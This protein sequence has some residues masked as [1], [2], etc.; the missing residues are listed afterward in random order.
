MSKALLFCVMV[1]W[2]V[3]FMF[4]A[5]PAARSISVAGEWRLRLDPNDAGLRED[6]FKKADAFPDII[7]LPSSTDEQHF[8][9]RN[10]ARDPGHLT[11]AYWFIGAVWYEREVT[12]PEA[13]KSKRITLF[14][15]RCHWETQAWF[16]GYPLGLQNSLS[17]PQAYEVSQPGLAIVT[18][19]KHR[20]TLR[21]DNRR[22][23]DVG[24]SSAVTE[25]GP[26][27]WNGIAGGMELRATDAVWIDKVFTYPDLARNLV[28]IKLR[29]RNS[30]GETQAAKL[31][32]AVGGGKSVTDINIGCHPVEVIEQDLRVAGPTE[33]WSE[34]SPTIQALDVSIAS[35]SAA[36]FFDEAH[37]TFGMR[38]LATA[39]KQML[40]NGRVIHLR[41]TVD[42]GSFPLKG[43]PPT[44]VA[45]WRARFHTYKDY[46]FNHVRF[47]S[48]C[49]PE[50]AFT[51]ADELGLI[52]QVE[53]PMWIPDGRVSANVLRTG[54]IRQ[55]AE[56]IVDTY[57]NHPSFGLMTMGNELGSA[58]DVF[59]RNLVQSLQA[60]DPRHLYTSTSAPDNMLRPDDYFVSAG[61]RWQNLRGDPRLEANPPDTDFDYRQ[62]VD[63]LDRPVVAHEL[64]QWTV[65]PDFSEAHSYTGPLQPRYLDF[66]RKALEQNDM[67]DQGEAFRKASG[68]LMVTLYKEEIESNLR[69]PGLTGFQL[70]GLTD[71]PGFGPAFIGVLNT[72]SESKGLI[73][74]Q[75]FRRFCGPT[76]PL[77]RLKKRT[78]TTNETLEAPI[79]VAHYGPTAIDALE[80][81][82]AVRDAAGRTVASGQQP[83]TKVPTGG[84]T[85]L[86][87]IHLALRNF[88]APARY[89]IQVSADAFANDWDIWL[90]PEKRLAPPSGLVIATRWD[91]ATRDQLAAGRTV[92]LLLDPR[93]P[94]RTTPTTFTTIFWAHSWFPERH[95]TMGI[96]CQ[97]SNPALADFPTDSHADWQ[98][99][100]LMSH[101]RAFVLNG[102]PAGFKPIVQVIDDAARSYRLGAVFEARVGAGKL[103]AT[104]FDLV[105][106]LDTRVAARQLRYSLI[107]YAAS[108]GFHSAT[109]LKPEL[110]DELFSAKN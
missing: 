106:S 58:L 77:L 41:G 56:A 79:E 65:F 23:I 9:N 74:P 76:V 26:G 85:A 98:W 45:T 82:W 19:G 4:S 52:L 59:L 13:W 72:L 78:W 28:H 15:E 53:N 57:G 43:Y 27:N 89:S 3:P 88:P 31:T 61:P 73:T 81:T 17:T 18:P 80:T 34:F 8:G 109:E 25:Q 11:R 91:A 1:A 60:R 67:F 7:H 35:A 105:N 24:E 50:A 102:G 87:A 95:E 12:I 42:N 66:Y 108:S 48:W 46:G 22:A 47:H 36:R 94:A 10:D 70:L 93:E 63:R 44:H 110:L 84:L 14:L 39:G 32:L 104:S 75:A 103:L 20:L 64:G 37:T 68:A 107:H 40:L 51:A 99:W 90:Y 29:I 6:W 5:E 16:D 100:D 38:A 49:P 71:W 96:L 21:V 55:E 62:Y 2:T 83:S 86:G 33:P 69:T 30:T 101:S 54:F 97:P 92:V